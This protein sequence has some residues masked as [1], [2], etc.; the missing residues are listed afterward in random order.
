MS[1]LGLLNR[2]A[3]FAGVSFLKGWR[4]KARRVR[5]LGFILSL[6]ALVGMWSH[7][8]LAKAE[9]KLYVTQ[10]GDDGIRFLTSIQSDNPRMTVFFSGSDTGLSAP[11][12]TAVDPFDEVLYASNFSGNTITTYALTASG[13]TAP[14]RTISGSGTGLFHPELLWLLITLDAAEVLVANFGLN[15]ITI[16][17]ILSL[18]P[19]PAT[20]LNDPAAIHR[21]LEQRDVN[22]TPLQTI[23]GSATGLNGPAGITVDPYTRKIYVSNS[24][25]N[26]ITVYPLTASGNTAPLQTI[27][28]SNTGLNGPF[29]VAVDPFL[30]RIYVANNGNNS[31]TDYDLTADGNV[32]PKQTVSGPNTGLNGPI[33]IAL[34]S[35]SNLLYVA[36][37]VGNSITAYRRDANGAFATTPVQTISGSALGLNG[38]LW[39]TLTKRGEISTVPPGG[40]AHSP[41]A[42]MDG[43]T[44]LHLFVRGIDGALY[45]NSRTDGTWGGFSAVPG[46]GQSKSGPAA[47][48]D[49]AGTLRLYI[50]GNDDRLYVNSRTSGTWGGW[51]AVPGGGQTRS[52]PAAVLD[53]DNNLWL[54]VRGLDDGIWIGSAD[55]PQWTSLGGKTVHTPAAVLEGTTLHIFVRGTDGRL[56]QNSRVGA[57][58]GGWSAVPG[59]GQTPSQPDAVMAGGALHLYVEGN[60][61]RLYRNSIKGGTWGGWKEVPGGGQTPDGPAAVLDGDQ[62]RLVVR[63]VDNNVYLITQ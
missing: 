29:G 10:Q 41:A 9:D 14:L 40:T 44:L 12:G 18:F 8:S 3:R 4:S 43:S 26:T 34:D 51:S 42:I 35:F 31:I 45:L 15:A 59:G 52:G 57:N 30:R 6:A 21:L 2:V 32:A 20:E 38:P 50:Q 17:A 22:L 7:P 47:V 16:Y 23:S 39:L 62:M 5:F 54:V 56:Y 46:G 24:G 37:N 61:T 13:N 1:S 60:D 27:S 63:G 55:N 36:N 33:G 19:T 48:F 11:R 49:S 58:F 25:G 28:G 53:S